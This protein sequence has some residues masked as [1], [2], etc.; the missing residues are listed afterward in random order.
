MTS[1]SANEVIA[2]WEAGR[3]HGAARRALAML[4]HVCPDRP[5]ADLARLSLGQRNALLLSA[6][7]R[8]FGEALLAV[9]NC[10][11]CHETVEVSL[12][13]TSLLRDQMPQ[14]FDDTLK[15]D[16][17]E[18][19]LRL[20]NT[21]DLLATEDSTDVDA[22]AAQLAARCVCSVRRNGRLVSP[23]ALPEH[24]V[25]ALAE[26]IATADPQAETVFELSCPACDEHWCCE[27]DIAGFFWKELRAHALRVLDHVHILARAYGWGEAEILA[28]SPA[29]RDWYLTRV[30][31]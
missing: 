8:T 13:C 26:R 10:P 15:V 12:S 11:A 30:Q 3:V 18:L 2:L 29:R 6:R 22:A 21:D 16:D 24:V 25:A 14:P 1:Q 28:L 20:L 4:E 9:T 23:Q 5:S 27:L 7:Q 19:T 17:Y 31:A